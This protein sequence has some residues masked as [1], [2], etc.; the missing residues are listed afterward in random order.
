MYGLFQAVFEKH[1]VVFTIGA[2]VASAGAAWAGRHPSSLIALCASIT[3][4]EQSSFIA[5]RAERDPM[6]VRTAGNPN[7]GTTLHV[8]YMPVCNIIL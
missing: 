4:H 7:I 2:S 1:N 3:D 5:A 6:D 8:K